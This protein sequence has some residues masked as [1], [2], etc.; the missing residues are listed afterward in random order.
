MKDVLKVIGRIL[1]ILAL[2]GVVVGATV[3]ITQATGFGDG[4]AAMTGERPE[5]PAGMEA[6]VR[7]EGG[8]G[9]GHGGSGDAG[10]LIRNGVIISLIVLVVA[11]GSWLLGRRRGKIQ[12]ETPTH[13][14]LVS[15]EPTA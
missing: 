10:H 2:V 6:G 14:A 11:G 4:G 15:G 3:A 13:V 7:P 1:I 9:G 12:R 8:E 5:P